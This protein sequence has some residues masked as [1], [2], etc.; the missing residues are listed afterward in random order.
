MMGLMQYVRSKPTLGADITYLKHSRAALLLKE[1]R[2]IY[3]NECEKKSEHT[4]TNLN[5]TIKIATFDIEISTKFKAKKKSGFS[6][7]LYEFH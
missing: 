7:S 2:K 5:W 3:M 6:V 1:E 4:E